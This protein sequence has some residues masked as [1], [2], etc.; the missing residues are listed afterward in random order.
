[1]I[2]PSQKVV[3]LLAIVTALTVGQASPA[4]SGGSAP[5]SNLPQLPPLKR[6]ERLNSMGIDMP[7]GGPLID[8]GFVLGQIDYVLTAD[9][10][11]LIDVAGLLQLLGSALGADALEKLREA[12]AGGVN[13]SD[14]DL[15]RLGYQV[16]YDPTTFSLSIAIS[17]SL[18]PRQSISLSG[19]QSAIAG[20]LMEPE[21][22][23]A[24]LTVLGNLDYVHKG[25][26]RGLGDP[27]LLLDSAVRLK[28]FVLENEASLQ[29]R[30][31]REGTRLVYDDRKNTA[32]YIVGDL[33]P[34]SRGF[35]GA[36]PMAG[37]SIERVY[38][39]L[40]PQRN[41]QPRGQRSFTLTKASSV[42]TFVN[43]SLVQQTRLAPGTYD[44]SDFPVAQGSNDVRLVVRD[45]AGVENVIDFSINFDRTLLAS[46]IS[47][48][49]LY[50]GVQTPFSSNGRRYTKRAIASGFFRRGL[51]EVLTAGGNFQIGT[52][53]GVVGVDAI[54][55]MPLGTVGFDLA[56][57]K[58]ESVGAGYAFNASFERNFARSASGSSALLL[59]Y[60]TT[61]RNFATATAVSP[62]N[63]YSHEVGATYSQGIGRDHFVSA[64][65]FYSVGRNGHPDQ[66]TGRLT[67]GWRANTRLFL[68]AEGS[69]QDR[70]TRTEA[71]VRLSLT[72]R[73]T[74][75]SS[76]MAEV[77]TRREGG[78]IQYQTSSGRGVGSY[79]A[80]GSIDYF[81][82]VGSFNGNANVMLNRAEAG[83]AHLTSYSPDDNRI[84][85]QRSSFRFGT[86]VAFA[87][88]SLALSRPIYDSFA[89]LKPHKTL[90]GAST[91]VSPNEKEYLSKSGVFGPGV[92]SDLSAYSSQT[93]TYD[94][95]EAPL[96]Y[97][98][99][100]GIA[101]VL[102][103]YR[104]GYLIGVGSSYS[105][106]FSG[107]LLK[108][109]GAPLA[110][111]AGHAHE[112]DQPDRPPVPMFTNRSGR[113][114]V[115]GL[116]SGRWR[117]ETDAGSRT[118]IYYIEIPENADGLVRGG[119]LL[120]GDS[121]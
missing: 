62:V 53:G 110:L 61:S 51:S 41:I 113:F 18:R 6:P 73:F 88:G 79:N 11:I 29:G 69:Y 54:W 97:D 58:V 70:G 92:V 35:S 85:D 56:A 102:P 28:G 60:Q 115:P 93:I 99:G 116:R 4:Q 24:Y 12:L 23:S 95:P 94:V 2:R 1:M 17:P 55:A 75:R 25:F 112:L 109:N 96:G 22:F 64:D 31:V 9:D 104:S 91:Y 47:E 37:L 74:P 57:S 78:R 48:F 118:L 13:V 49:G 8:N 46:G 120:P 68:T 76:M 87:G 121:E 101:Q 81:D 39:D 52:R 10:R 21:D 14:A 67:Y 82:G 33:R 15:R 83:F 84:I 107:Q 5:S 19:N 26:D 114:A 98:L 100:T 34:I 77:D 65:G 32:R 27:N 44:I 36:S 106:T 86:S 30:F 72:Y 38:A 40:E 42:E 45:D 111:T 43:G 20:P 80:Q 3:S 89:L 117:I 105:V 119:A 7:L 103:P 50:A 90:K 59:T 63:P 108:A 16:T 71:G 66:K